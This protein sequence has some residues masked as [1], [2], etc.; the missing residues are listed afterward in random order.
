MNE[1]AE[2]RRYLKDDEDR[3]GIPKG[4]LVACWEGDCD[5]DKTCIAFTIPGLHDPECN[6]YLTDLGPVLGEIEIRDRR[7]APWGMVPADDGLD[8]AAVVASAEAQ[9]RADAELM[10]R[11]EIVAA[12]ATLYEAGVLPEQIEAALKATADAAL[13][14]AGMLPE[15]IVDTLRAAAPQAGE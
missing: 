3:F 9:E 8:L 10:A 2:I 6:A 4:A 13:R 7:E 1:T 5:E 12:I 11:P 15:Q 14:E